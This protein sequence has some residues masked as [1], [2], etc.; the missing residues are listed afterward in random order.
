MYFDLFCRY[1]YEE[2]ARKIQDLFLEGSRMAAI[3]AVPD[4]L[5]D[6]ISLCGPK[7]RIAER[8]DMWR[9][10]GITTLI[11]AVSGIDALRTMAE[12]VL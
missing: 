10:C 12:L 9:N 1:G 3:A 6:E 5:V 8:L 4:E 7:E 2:A 11:C